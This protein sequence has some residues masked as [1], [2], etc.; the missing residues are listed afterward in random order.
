LVFVKVVGYDWTRLRH[1]TASWSLLL[2]GGALLA[3]G[4]LLRVLDESD[5]PLTAVAAVTS[6]P[7][8]G[9]AVVAA[10]QLAGFDFDRESNRPLGAALLALAGLF[11]ALGALVFWSLRLTA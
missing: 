9:L 2:I 6:P 11:G 3:A 10:T 1:H 7:G 5:E 8:L 4:Y